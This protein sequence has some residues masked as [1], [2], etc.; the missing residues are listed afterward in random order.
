MG[1]DKSICQQIKVPNTGFWQSL[2]TN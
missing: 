2:Q 1:V